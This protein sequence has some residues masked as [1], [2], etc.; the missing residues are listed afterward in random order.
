M[1]EERENLTEAELA[2]YHYRH[3]DDPE[4]DGEPVAAT[5]ARPLS[6]T[7]SFRL[8]AQEA[9]AIREASENSGL[10]QSEWIRAACTAASASEPRNRPEPDSLSPEQAREVLAALVAAEDI[11][12]PATRAS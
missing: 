1:P 2:E 11:I 7:M 9:A 12:R 6:V 3:K 5:I 10:S 4:L 8:P